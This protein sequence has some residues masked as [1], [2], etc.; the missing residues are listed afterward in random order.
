MLSVLL[1]LGAGML[2]SSMARRSGRNAAARALQARSLAEAGV[3]DALTKL[4]KDPL[5]P[6]GG[7]A[8]ASCFSYLEN[9]SNLDTGA[10]TGSYRVTCNWLWANPPYLV[11]VIVSEGISGSVDQPDALC[12]IQA[13]VDLSP[14]DRST[15]A[16]NPKL[17][18][19]IDWQE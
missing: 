14:T 5:F 3:A 1:A 19:V 7:V 4:R 8:Q 17:Y 9:V 12:R 13:T 15:G 18:Q 2:K 6:P 10:P 16:P 11:M